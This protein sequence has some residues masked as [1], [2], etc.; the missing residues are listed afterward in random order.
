MSEYLHKNKHMDASIDIL[1][2][3]YFGGNATEADK[4]QLDA[5]IAQSPENEAEFMRMTRLYEML[6]VP[7]SETINFD[8]QTAKQKFISHINKSQKLTSH[9][10]PKL[11]MRN[12][13]LRAAVIVGI[14]VAASLLWNVSENKEIIVSTH[15]NIYETQL[16]NGTKIQLAANSNITYNKKTDVGK[17]KEIKL[18]GKALF[19]VEGSANE[20]LTVIAGETFIQ[21]IGTIFEVSAYP[22]NDFIEVKVSS[23][24]VKFYTE[25]NAGVTIKA[26]ET[27]FY[28]KISKTFK[29]LSSNKMSNDEKS[30]LLNLE[31]ISLTQAVGVISHAYNVDI[32]IVDVRDAKK[33][34][35]VSF[36]NENIDTV[37]A[38]LA[39][40]LGLVLEMDG[41]KYL[42]KE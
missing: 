42:L 6:G 1:L 15:A 24:E 40:T 2:A 35:T 21:D 3:K 5:W 25:N 4:K 29:L 23:G 12:W 26:N 16:S 33:Q 22:E 37:M 20:A 17:R 39:Q 18:V 28:D 38:V 32:N 31:N 10:Q 34:I 19:D 14:V 27:G 9:S 30:I 41:D 36:E 13:I 8:E 7:E 11:F